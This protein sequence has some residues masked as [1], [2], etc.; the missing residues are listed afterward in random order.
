MIKVQDM[1]QQMRAT[2]GPNRPKPFALIYCTADRKRGTGGQIREIR[3]AFLVSTRRAGKSR[4]W[5]VNVQPLG[6]RDII[7]IHLD[8]ILYFNNQDLV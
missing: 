1:V 3:K 2:I 5:K 7:S 6:T 4:G 8:L